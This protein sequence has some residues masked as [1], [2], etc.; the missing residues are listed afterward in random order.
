MTPTLQEYI[1]KILKCNGTGA[2]ELEALVENGEIT[3]LEASIIRMRVASTK[4]LERVKDLD[5]RTIV[6]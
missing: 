1:T 4:L 5:E 3:R 6:V 2:Q